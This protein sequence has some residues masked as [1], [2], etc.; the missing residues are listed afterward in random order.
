MSDNFVNQR[1]ES[2]SKIETNIVD[3]LK[4]FSD[5]FETYTSSSENKEDCFIL[6]NKN[7]CNALNTVSINLKKEIEIF[8][9]RNDA[10]NSNEDHQVIL[11]VQ[12]NQKNMELGEAIL[13][14]ELEHVQKII[15]ESQNVGIDCVFQPLKKSYIGSKYPC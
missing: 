3:L 7:L 10:S 15:E 11:P 13:V 2:L 9:E 12:V 1:L 8:D 14:S 5:L 4:K 6:Q